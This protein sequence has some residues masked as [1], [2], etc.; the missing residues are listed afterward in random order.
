MKSATAPDATTLVIH[1][2]SPVGNVL[3]QLE[4]F[5]MLPQAR[6][7]VEG[8]QRDGKGL[9]TYH[10]ELH[11]PIVTGGAY[12]ITPVREEG[13]DGVQ[14]GPELLRPAVGRHRASR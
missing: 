10:P 4:T 3:A 12:T 5:F 9:K 6:L 13:D 2:E 7:A 1:Y 14:A 8:R 11:L